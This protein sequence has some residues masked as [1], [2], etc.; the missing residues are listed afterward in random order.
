MSVFWILLFAIVFF[1][2]NN[3]FGRFAVIYRQE[4]ELGKTLE[5]TLILLL[6]RQRDRVTNE[7]KDS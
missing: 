3:F 6:T 1:F 2:L 7:K 5:R 4:L